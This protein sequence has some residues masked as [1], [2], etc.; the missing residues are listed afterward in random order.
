MVSIAGNRY[1]YNSFQQNKGKPVEFG[2]AK[3]AF[4]G[5]IIEVITM[6]NVRR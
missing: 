6:M 3:P 5:D 2:V 1:L 4:K